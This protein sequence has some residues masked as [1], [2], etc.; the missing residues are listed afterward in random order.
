MKK[1]LLTITVVA[2]ATFS[3]SQQISRYVVASGVNYSA[4][5][6]ISLSSTIGEP[7]VA[8]LTGT[9][10][11]LTQGFQQSFPPLTCDAP[12][13]LQLQTTFDTQSLDRMG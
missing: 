1:I 4:A 12:T 9:G 3:F 13:N 2:F 5:S 7:M 10:L 6:G 8:T 11:V